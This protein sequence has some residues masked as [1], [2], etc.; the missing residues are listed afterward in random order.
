[1]IS[2]YIFLVL[3]GIGLSFSQEKICGSTE[4]INKSLENFPE[5]KQVLENLN[6]FTK[7]FIEQKS[8]VDKMILHILFPPW[9]TLFIIMAPSVFPKT[10]LCL[11]CKA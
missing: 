1:M 7:E 10:K 4:A 11:V 3:L 6:A 8:Y 2:K 9:F 5:K